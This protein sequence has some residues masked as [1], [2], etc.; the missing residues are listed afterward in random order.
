MVDETRHEGGS[1]MVYQREEG[2]INPDAYETS[3]TTQGEQGGVAHLVHG[4]I[5]QKQVEGVNYLL[6]IVVSC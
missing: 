2:L 3:T 6:S 1:T 4:W 5:Q